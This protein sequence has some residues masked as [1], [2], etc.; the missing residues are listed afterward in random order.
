MGA[1][2]S[3]SEVIVANGSCHPI[4]I[5]YQ[6]ENGHKSSI[7]IRIGS[8]STVPSSARNVSGHLCDEKAAENRIAI[9][10][11]REVERGRDRS[12]SIIITAEG[13]VELGEEDA[14]APNQDWMWISSQDR[15]DHRP[16]KFFVANASGKTIKVQHVTSD[17]T[18]VGENQCVTVEPDRTEVLDY[19]YV[20][21]ISYKGVP[22][23]QEPIENRS[24]VRKS[25]IVCEDGT[26]KKTAQLFGENIDEKKKWTV[27]GE[28]FKKVP[29]TEERFMEKL[30][31]LVPVLEMI[32]GILATVAN[33]VNLFVR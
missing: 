14:S 33:V 5:G 10:T 12:T 8:I 7:V 11:E 29:W 32:H 2:M 18:P 27:N 17:G 20:K 19:D 9:F 24:V 31:E 6:D 30:R 26:V 28:S 22:L 16:R 4:E 25:L 23:Q 13:T 3:A 15:I 21:I 1:K